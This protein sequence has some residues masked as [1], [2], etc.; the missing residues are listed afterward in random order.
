LY[1]AIDWARK[2]GVK[3][4]FFFPRP[5]LSFS[6]V[7]LIPFLLLLSVM[8]DIHG[9]PGSQNGFDNSGRRGNVTWHLKQENINRTLNVVSNLSKEFAKPKYKDTVTILQA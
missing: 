6:N 2:H 9:A 8:V 7:R 1:K 4:S 3:G 5:E